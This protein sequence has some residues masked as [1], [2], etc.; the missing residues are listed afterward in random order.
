MVS[1][2]GHLREKCG[3]DQLHCE[4]RRHPHVNDGWPDEQRH[5]AHDEEHQRGQVNVEDRVSRATSE[6]HYHFHFAELTLVFVFQGKVTHLL[7]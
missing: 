3:D 1:V 6:R 4:G 5:V 2:V 7:Q